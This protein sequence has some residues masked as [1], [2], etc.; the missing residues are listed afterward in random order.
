VSDV[1]SVFLWALV[2]NYIFDCYSYGSLQDLLIF[3]KTAFPDYF[4]SEN[5]LH[6]TYLLVTE[7]IYTV[8]KCN[9]YMS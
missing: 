2:L 1:S 8:T 3:N 7:T 4:Y 9:S 6:V 5:G